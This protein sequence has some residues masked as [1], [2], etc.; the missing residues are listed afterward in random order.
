[1]LIPVL[2]VPAVLAHAAYCRK[3]VQNEMLDL[4]GIP[5]VL[6]QCQVTAPPPPF[7]FQQMQ[8]CSHCQP[9][10]PTSGL[11]RDSH[12]PE[13]H[14]RGLPRIRYATFDC[15]EAAPVMHSSV[16]TGGC[17]N[18]IALLARHKEHGRIPSHL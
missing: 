5:L 4:G 18:Y 9:M 12:L 7:K 13:V 10:C 3:E 6:S 14:T 17:L 16:I 1:M 15:P 11:C 2:L 8:C